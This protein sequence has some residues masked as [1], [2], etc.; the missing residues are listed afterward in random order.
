MGKLDES[1]NDEEDE[2]EDEKEDEVS[3]STQVNGNA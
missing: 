2:K 1:E 3:H